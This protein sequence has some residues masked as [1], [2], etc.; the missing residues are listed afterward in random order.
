MSPSSGALNFL[1]LIEYD[2]QLSDG[3]GG[4]QCLGAPGRDDNETDPVTDAASATGPSLGTPSLSISSS[5][6]STT[7]PDVEST[8]FARAASLCINDIGPSTSL[9]PPSPHSF[10]SSQNCSSILS[11]SSL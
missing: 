8:V 9:S 5:S 3:F 7:T 10:K 4:I 2:T 6:L 1:S 11:S